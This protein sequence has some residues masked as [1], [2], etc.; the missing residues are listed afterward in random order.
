MDPAQQQ[1]LG[2]TLALAALVAGTL[3]YDLMV[4]HR[5]ER[6]AATQLDDEIKRYGLV[7]L[8]RVMLL[9]DQ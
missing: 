1:L 8:V 5:A 7:G 2:Q 6:R 3:Q 9:D 4:K